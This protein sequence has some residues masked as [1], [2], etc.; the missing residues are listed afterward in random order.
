[1]KDAFS[2]LPTIVK[3][4]SQ[5]MDISPIGL[6]LYGSSVEVEDPRDVDILVV[7]RNDLSPV[8]KRKLRSA[9][10]LEIRSRLELAKDLDIRIRT[11][12]EF[13]KM[14]PLHLGIVQ[15]Y[16][17]LDDTNSILQ[18]ILSNARQ[19]SDEWKTKQVQMAD[20]SWV[21][22]VKGKVVNDEKIEYSQ[23]L[24]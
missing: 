16:R 9:I 10:G 23:E 4:R 6:V 14:T 24:F 19:L 20:G 8:E 17:I 11:F 18:T 3:D 22:F 12:E 21:I 5:E 7:V 15:G 2:Q 1:M 13:R